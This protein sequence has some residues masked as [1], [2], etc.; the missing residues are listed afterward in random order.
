MYNQRTATAHAEDLTTKKKGHLKP[1]QAYM[2][3]YYETKLKSILK[4]AF[5]EHLINTD[6]TESEFAFRQRKC[7]ELLA[8]ES[9]KVKQE[10]QE[11]I[12]KFASQAEMVVDYTEEVDVSSKEIQERNLTVQKFVQSLPSLKQSLPSTLDQ[13]IARHDLFKQSL[14]ISVRERAG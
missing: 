10:V 6:K 7:K 1:Y 5:A 2:S 4:A 11:Y 9:E 13:S 8:G 12:E 3:L 14:K